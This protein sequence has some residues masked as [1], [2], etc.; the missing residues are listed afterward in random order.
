MRLRLLRSAA[1]FAGTAFAS[2]GS[3]GGLAAIAFGGLTLFESA[4]NFLYDVGRDFFLTHDASRMFY[5][6]HSPNP[7]GPLVI[8]M[9][10]Y[11]SNP[12]VKFLSF[13]PTCSPLLLDIVKV[14]AAT[15]VSALHNKAGYIGRRKHV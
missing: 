1:I 12:N 5:Q 4:F 11:Y 8:V 6:Y 2:R 13:Y 9:I 10:A 7:C 14:A 3:A 15:S